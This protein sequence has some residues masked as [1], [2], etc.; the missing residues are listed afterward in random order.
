MNEFWLNSAS[1]FLRI[2]FFSYLQEKKQLEEAKK[3]MEAERIKLE[4]WSKEQMA[5][6]AQRE[7]ARKQRY[8][9]III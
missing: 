2:L 8:T 1:E 4:E 7:E 5:I 9:R 3:R 6:L